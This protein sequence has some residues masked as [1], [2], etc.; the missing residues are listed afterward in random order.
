MTILILG[1]NGML[2]HMVHRYFESKGY[3]CIT[4]EYRYPSADFSESIKRFDGDC[5][6]NCIGAIPQKTKE[7]SVN[8]ELPIWLSENTKIKIIHPGTDC[9]MDDDAYGISKKI[10]R[11]YIVSKSANTKIIRSS[12]IGPELN[13]NA[14]LLDWFLSSNNTVNGYTSAMWNGITTL[15]WSKQCMQLINN[16][17]S[18][19]TETVISSNCISKYELLNKIKMVFEKDINILPVNKGENKCLTGDIV[20]NE[21]EMQLKELREYLHQNNL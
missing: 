13:S 16:W 17:N 1:H 20:A 15:E 3:T 21:I 5:I 4:T 9:E 19:S 12:I 10:A 2:G 18:Y 14:S 8:T 7:F 11:D 6:I